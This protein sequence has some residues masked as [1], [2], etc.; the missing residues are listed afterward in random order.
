MSVHVLAEQ[1]YQKDYAL[2]LRIENRTQGQVEFQLR[3][4]GPGI[5]VDVLAEEAE[6]IRAYEGL[7]ERLKSEI[8]EQTPFIVRRIDVGAASL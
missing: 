7:A 5:Y 8:E 6:T 2:R 4:R 3:T 1:Y